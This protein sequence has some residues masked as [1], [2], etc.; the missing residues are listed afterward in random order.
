MLKTLPPTLSHA[1][2][3]HT[4]DALLPNDAQISKKMPTGTVTMAKEILRTV[5]NTEGTAEPVC[6]LCHE[7]YG[8][9]HKLGR[10]GRHYTYECPF[11]NAER[12]WLNEKR[13]EVLF[14]CGR[15]FCY[16]PNLA[17]GFSNYKMHPSNAL[18]DTEPLHD[19]HD[20]I[21]LSQSF[22]TRHHDAKSTWSDRPDHSISATTLRVHWDNVISIAADH[23]EHLHTSPYWRARASKQQKELTSKGTF[24]EHTTRLCLCTLQQTK[25]IKSIQ[26]HPAVVKWFVN[27]FDLGQQC[28]TSPFN[29]Y[30]GL[31]REQ[32]ALT[33]TILLDTDINLDKTGM[34]P[35]QPPS[36]R[37]SAS[38]FISVQ[39]SAK[40]WQK[41]LEH[42]HQ[43]CQTQPNLTIVAMIVLDGKSSWDAVKATVRKSAGIVLLHCP[44]HTLTVVEPNGLRERLDT[45]AGHTA[46]VFRQPGHKRAKHKVNKVSH[47][48]SNMHTI[49]GPSE[50]SNTF[51]RHAN[52]ACP[53]ECI[54]VVYHNE[55][56]TATDVYT[57][58]APKMQNLC[59]ALLNTNPSPSKIWNNTHISWKCYVHINMSTMNALTC[60][61][62]KA[63]CLDAFT[64][65]ARLNIHDGKYYE[66]RMK[67]GYTS[68]SAVGYLV[69]LGLSATEARQKLA[70]IA[71]S[72]CTF[73]ELI[74]I[75][76]TKK[77]SEMLISAGIPCTPEFQPTSTTRCSE[78]T[79]EVGK[80]FAR[81]STLHTGATHGKSQLCILCAT[82]T[83]LQNNPVHKKKG[84]PVPKARPAAARSALILQL[85][86]GPSLVT[87]R[88]E[89][90]KSPTDTPLETKGA[91]TTV[92][93]LRR[94]NS[95]DEKQS[96]S[97]ETTASKSCET[98]G[99][100]AVGAA[101]ANP[102]KEVFKIAS[103]RT[104]RNGDA[105]TYTM[106]SVNQQR[107]G[108]FPEETIP[109]ASLSLKTAP[110]G[111][112]TWTFIRRAKKVTTQ[113]RKKQKR[114]RAS[115][116]VAP[117]QQSP[118]TTMKPHSHPPEPPHVTSSKR[119]NAKTEGKLRRKSKKS[120]KQ[121]G[122]K[123]V[124]SGAPAAEKP[125]EMDARLPEKVHAQHEAT[126]RR[127]Q[128][129]L[130]EHHQL[131]LEEKGWTESTANPPT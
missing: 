131:P 25:T 125:D 75:K 64:Q 51:D 78:C 24:L 39:T 21:F 61:K 108:A 18:F 32:P 116:Q 8:D 40:A 85:M 120:R 52:S 73:L 67:L 71:T 111:S 76:G 37:Y 96:S 122:S 43:S 65:A 63:K 58:C 34:A 11:F 129:F 90:T 59:N 106:K 107:G 109:A 117:S 128:R 70:L 30:S 86:G 110:T 31:C 13:T 130:H 113:L 1:L 123:S 80:L 10:L 48:L 23:K 20:C 5:R 60:T 55:K 36:K 9:S 69:T 62:S 53:H 121:A 68:T 79:R 19:N 81:M 47:T 114:K 95:K 44:Q 93:S 101:W 83:T 14:G 97:V 84:K 127:V 105:L 6:L 112:A 126:R 77:I 91:E 12:D 45:N 118:S 49:A 50:S 100:H 94:I 29:C 41:R 104:T 3:R 26:P 102:K 82:K 54:F 15:A 57:Q 89:R 4:V 98:T 38:S 66:N 103:I 87:T 17:V 7:K 27:V 115:P 42:A 28:D 72:E 119:K 46:K 74:E 92:S 16:D 88:T 124:N 56:K 35:P 99:T 2:D 22:K 33:P